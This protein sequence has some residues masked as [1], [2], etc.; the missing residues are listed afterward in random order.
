MID[1]R[2]PELKQFHDA[3]KKNPDFNRVEGGAGGRRNKF[4]FVSTKG[5]SGY[6]LTAEVVG[7]GFGFDVD[8]TVKPITK[9]RF[10]YQSYLYHSG[11]SHTD[12]QGN[13][14][15]YDGVKNASADI[16]AIYC[17]GYLLTTHDLN[18]LG[19]VDIT[20]FCEELTGNIS[21]EINCTVNAHSIFD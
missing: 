3:V 5:D 4:I 11:K 9:K 1:V 21:T 6:E 19:G 10:E 12:S 2:S 13:E 8:F 20:K 16:R 14:W 7:V 17:R 18:R 15:F